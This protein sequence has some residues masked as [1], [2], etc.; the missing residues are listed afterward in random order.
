MQKHHCLNYRNPTAPSQWY[1]QPVLSTAPLPPSAHLPAAASHDNIIEHKFIIPIFTLSDL[2]QPHF[3]TFAIFLS[4]LHLSTPHS[5]SNSG[6]NSPRPQ[7]PNT[8]AK[9]ASILH[10]VT[11]P[12]HQDNTCWPQNFIL[13]PSL[14]RNPNYPNPAMKAALYPPPPTITFLFTNTPEN[15]HHLYTPPNSRG[16]HTA[17]RRRWPT[18]AQPVSSSS[19]SSYRSIS[20]PLLNLQS[21]TQTQ[22]TT[23][24]YSLNPKTTI[25]NNIHISK[26]E[27]TGI[28]TEPQALPLWF[29]WYWA[30][31][32]PLNRHPQLCIH[33][34]LEF[35]DIYKTEQSHRLWL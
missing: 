9:S 32:K 13:C 35:A 18:Y 7:Y 25:N 15:N 12:R 34:A 1:N 27:F 8:T 24:R 31:P 11:A 4:H 19:C 5:A 3:D 22:I 20:D 33:T 10:G 16:C 14:F 23:E 26:Q 2:L 21:R 30:T 29:R 28:K 6:L 17:S